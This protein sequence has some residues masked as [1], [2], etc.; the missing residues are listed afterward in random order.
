MARSVN[1]RFNHSQYTSRACPVCTCTGKRNQKG[2]C[3]K[4]ASCGYSAPADY[5]SALNILLKF[6]TAKLV[7]VGWNNCL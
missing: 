5:V 1:R 6:T 3:F 4:C 2:K 7:P